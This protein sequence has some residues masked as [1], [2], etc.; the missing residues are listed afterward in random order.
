MFD[1][2]GWADWWF[3]DVMLNPE[4]HNKNAQI[5]V[6]VIWTMFIFILTGIM[7][8]GMVWAISKII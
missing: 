8:W 4:K 2:Y 3:F 6:E 5:I 1:W 7:F